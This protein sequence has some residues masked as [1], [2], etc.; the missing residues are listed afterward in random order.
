MFCAGKPIKVS[1][2]GGSITAGWSAHD[3]YNSLTFH[4]YLVD[5]L[6]DQYGDQL[7]TGYNGAVNAVRSNYMSV[8][9][10][11]R[12]PMDSDVVLLEMAVNDEKSHSLP[13]ELRRCV[14]KLHAR[15]RRLEWRWQHAQIDPDGS[16]FSSSHM[17][18]EH[19]IA[20]VHAQ[21]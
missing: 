16:S 4:S 9:Y 13:E 11:T 19:A 2:L 3:H 7:V 17:R 6:K 10:K 12:I 1:V 15:I 5:Y 20:T 14:V 21:T 8:C 18:S